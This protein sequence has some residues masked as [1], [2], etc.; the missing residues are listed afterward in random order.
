MDI[1]G[2]GPEIYVVSFP[3]VFKFAVLPVDGRPVR[4]HNPGRMRNNFMYRHWKSKIA[5]IL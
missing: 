3:R 2:G 4:A 1:G 5:I